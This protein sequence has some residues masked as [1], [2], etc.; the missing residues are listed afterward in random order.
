MG[1]NHDSFGIYAVETSLG[2]DRGQ[3]PGCLI[4]SDAHDGWHCVRFLFLALMF[5]ILWGG[6]VITS[7]KSRVR[8]GARAK[9]LPQLLE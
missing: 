4:E 9:R 3:S 7:Y 8:S 2:P 1:V 6:F 5:F